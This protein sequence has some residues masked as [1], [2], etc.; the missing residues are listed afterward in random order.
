MKPKSRRMGLKGS[1]L[2]TKKFL[3]YIHN[4]KIWNIFIFIQWHK[5]FW[6]VNDCNL[7]WSYQSSTINNI[8]VKQMPMCHN[9]SF[10]FATKARACKGVGQEGSSKLTSHAPGSVGKSEGMNLHTPK[11]APILGV[12]VLM[13][14]Q[15]FIE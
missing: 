10:G 2:V 1:Y 13:D 9:P 15:I 14:S 11:W 4:V 5:P 3:T 12:G 7:L 8:G 6:N